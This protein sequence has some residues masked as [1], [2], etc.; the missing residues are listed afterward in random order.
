MSY[1]TRLADHREADIKTALSRLLSS[2]EKQENAF[3]RGEMTKSPEFVHQRIIKLPLLAS[4]HDRACSQLET[5]TREDWKKYNLA[6]SKDEIPPATR[7]EVKRIDKLIEDRNAYLGALCAVRCAEPIVRQLG[8]R[9]ADWLLAELDPGLA[10]INGRLYWP[11][12]V[13][14]DKRRLCVVGAEID[15]VIYFASEGEEIIQAR[16]QAEVA[17]IDDHIRLLQDVEAYRS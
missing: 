3:T 5:L 6:M 1:K 17:G 14:D 16:A 11:D 13:L 9:A 7:E 10:E 15:P 8:M 4:V 12:A 2:D